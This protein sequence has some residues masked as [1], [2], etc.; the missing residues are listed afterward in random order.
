MKHIIMGKRLKI[1]EEQLKRLVSLN[2]YISESMDGFDHEGQMDELGGPMY[3]SKEGGFEH[4]HGPDN[5]PDHMAEL[6]VSKMDMMINPEYLKD[7][8]LFNEFMSSLSS[9]IR[10]KYEDRSE[11]HN[12]SEENESMDNEIYESI[13]DNFKRFL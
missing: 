4:G 3:K 9:K 13:R 5:D 12:S 2:K 8:N 6:V 1:T 7:Q 10:E 11:F